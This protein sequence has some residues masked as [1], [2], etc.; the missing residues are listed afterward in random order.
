MAAK[1]AIAISVLLFAVTLS[2]YAEDC[3]GF[4]NIAGKDKVLVV[5]YVKRKRYAANHS[6]SPKADEE[7]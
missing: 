2:A 3:P 1:Y 5:L 6:R 7:V 4:L